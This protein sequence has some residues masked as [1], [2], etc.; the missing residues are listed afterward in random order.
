MRS[1]V[2]SVP[3][4]GGMLIVEVPETEEEM[5]QGLSGRTSIP[6]GRGMLFDMRTPGRW[7]FSTRA[8]L[9][10]LDLVMLKD[11][12]TVVEIARDVRPRPQ[13]V[14]GS[15]PYSWVLELPGGWARRRGLMPSHIVRPCAPGLVPPQAGW[16]SLHELRR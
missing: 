2:L 5:R 12:G 8:M 9:V 3:P 11:D 6:E 7:S 4:Y 13:P 15:V 10:P 14:V 1:A 16:H